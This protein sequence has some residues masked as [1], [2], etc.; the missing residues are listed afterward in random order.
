MEMVKSKEE[1]LKEISDKGLTGIPS[2]DRPWEKYYSKKNIQIGNVDMSLF[3]YIYDRNKDR[4]DLNALRYM[5]KQTN[6]EHL[7]D[8]I[9][10][11]AKKFKKYGVKEEDYVAL[12]MPLTPEVIY[13]LYGLDKIGAC[14][15]LIDPRVP[16][17]RMNFY[18]SLTESKL[19]AIIQPYMSTMRKVINKNPI[20]TVIQVSPIEY[21]DKKERIEKI[22]ALYS[23]REKK[24]LFLRTMRNELMNN[25]HNAK[26]IITGGSKIIDFNKFESNE[27]I[28]LGNIQYKPNKASVVEYTS[29][30]TGVP[31]ALGLT[32][33]GMNITAEQLRIIN[34]ARPGETMLSIMPPFI[35][36]GAVAGIHNSLSCGFEMILIP[37]FSVEIFADLIK[38]YKP[39][40]IIC[41]PSMFQA[42]MK[43]EK[44][45]NED[46]SYLNRLIFGGDRTTPEYEIQVNN[47]LSN[48]N[49]HKTLIK[50]GGM[51]EFSSCAFETPYEETKK[52]G[53]YGIPLPMVDAKIMKDDHTECGYY[54]IGEIYISSP[55]E[56]IGYI[57][58]PKETEKFFYIDENGKK[59][60][61]TGDLGYVDTDGAFVHT[62][63]KKQMIVRPDGHNV[64][65]NEIENE[66]I[67]TGLVSNCVVIGIKSETD[68]SGEYPH[69]FIEL[70]NDVHNKDDALR[71]II[72]T[73]NG[74]L[75]PRDRPNSSDYHIINMIYTKE[76]KLDR[77]AII[78]KLKSR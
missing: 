52:L 15:N 73:I 48:H 37:N 16:A 44:L 7:F 10:E 61:R 77:N 28:E 38:T 55:Q 76:G 41:V 13:M 9:E 78:K 27:D 8:K 65:P 67:K 14:T 20:D 56:M 71:Y 3:D 33:K 19:A 5:G 45:V 58:N 6:Y 59:W 24:K 47:W 29:G 18:L 72:K 54:E 49:C 39:N 57:N 68:V 26:S 30:T 66:I 75:P 46:M 51:A 12:A 25:L 69:A 11:T 50:G 36:Y 2:T 22:D 40:N 4:Q 63:R 43:S 23:S 34:E 53:I 31:K 1:I 74:V 64:F 60:G 35:S 42:V 70:K 32:A 21:L 62:S 17:E